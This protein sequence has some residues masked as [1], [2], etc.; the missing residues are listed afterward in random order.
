MK[1]RHNKKIIFVI[2]TVLLLTVAVGTTLAYIVTSTDPVKN[3]FTSS[4]VA[5]AVIENGSTTENDNDVV[6]VETKSNVKIKNTGDTESYIRAAV[7]V[8]WKAENGN[9]WAQTPVLDTDY[10]ITYASDTNWIQGSDGFH[11]YTKPVNPS[12]PSEPTDGS[13][14][15]NVLISDARQ[16]K[17]GP[18]GSDGTQYYLSI[19]IVASGIQST[20]SKVFNE[21][22]DKSGLYVGTD[23][24]LIQKQ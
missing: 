9:V 23:G 16:L 2:A 12:K 21:Q 17:T 1:F 4:K 15:T 5:T 6:S 3:I 10:S 7:V 19:E 22:W 18:V 8:T 20:P 13:N 14:Y 11:Y 24:N